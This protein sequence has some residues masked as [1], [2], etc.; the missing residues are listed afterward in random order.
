MTNIGEKL[1]NV[2]KILLPEINNKKYYQCTL[3]T[4]FMHGLNI[5]RY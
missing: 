4:F 5:K 3:L 2:S 1:K